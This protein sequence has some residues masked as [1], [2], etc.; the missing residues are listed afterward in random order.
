MRITLPT[1]HFKAVAR[2][3]LTTSEALGIQPAGGTA[4]IMNM[5]VTDNRCIA[6]KGVCI[7]GSYATL[8]AQVV[9]MNMDMIRMLNPINDVVVK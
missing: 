3:V 9:S 4:N 7:Q 5:P 6:F 1:S 2:D 8:S